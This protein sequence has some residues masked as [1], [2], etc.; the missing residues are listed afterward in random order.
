LT[1]FGSGRDRKAEQ[2]I[3]IDAKELTVDGR[4]E[5]ITR[6]LGIL[7]PSKYV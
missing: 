7:V 1:V 2:K 4:K 6:K 5:I 3:K